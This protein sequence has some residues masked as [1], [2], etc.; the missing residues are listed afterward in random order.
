MPEENRDLVALVAIILVAAFLRLMWPGIAEFKFDEATVARSALALSREADI[1]GGFPSSIP[2]VDQP[3]FMAVLLAPPFAVSRNPATAVFYLGLLSTF[4]VYLSY[5]LGKRLFDTRVAL[6]ASTFFALAPWVVFYT[7][8]LWAQNVPFFT[9]IM[10]LGLYSA[11]RKQRPRNIFIALFA[12]GILIGL[13]LGNIMLA[14]VVL[15]VILIHAP[16]VL[17]DRR[18]EFAI[19][20][21]LGLAVSFVILAPYLLESVPTIL[22]AIRAG[23]EGQGG[24]RLWQRVTEMTRAGTGYQFHALVGEQFSEYYEFL[25]F[26]DLSAIDFAATWLMRIG[27]VYVT[28]RAIYNSVT[29]GT[30]ASGYAIVSLWVL[31][32]L[33]GWG[34]SGFDP[35]P[36]RYIMVYPAQHIAMAVLIIDAIDWATSWR[37]EARAVLYGVA[38]LWVLVLGGWQVTEYIGMKRF[39]DNGLAT[40]GGFDVPARTV[41]QTAQEARALAENDLPIIIYSDGDDPLTEGDAA[42][43]TAAL[44]EQALQLVEGDS[45]TVMP[46]SD[47]FVRIEELEDKSFDVQLETPD[48]T[49]VEVPVSRMV[50]GVDLL[51]VTVPPGDIEPGEKLELTLDWRIWG[52]PPTDENYSYTVQLFTDDGLRWSQWD[53]Q[54]LRTEYWQPSDV[55]R[56]DVTL[57][58]FEDAP[59]DGFY[60]LVIAMYVFQ[61]DGT[62]QGVEVRDPDGNIAGRFLILPYMSFQ[63]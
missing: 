17:A 23:G 54:F 26:P 27:V 43:W 55:I 5:L 25:P 51:Q 13:Y 59:A 35:Q 57:G 18:R 28:I 1:P 61:P 36:H 14:G 34:L 62:G 40:S 15:L 4:T 37:A 8:K 63:Q 10:M 21:V 53:R 3:P 46:S 22:E 58:V 49:D 24:F 12:L 31:I 29:T 2:G 39:I 9:V 20:A 33:I 60:Q 42:V 44:G 19:W 6:L 45:L 11:V 56:T 48:E 16:Q 50:N 7:R 41:W 30:L 38:V 32:P 52:I 47:R